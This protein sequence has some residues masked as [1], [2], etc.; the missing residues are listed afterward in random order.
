[1]ESSF[2]LNYIEKLLA[3]QHRRIEI[4]N[5]IQDEKADLME[6]FVSLVTSFA[7]RLGNDAATD[8]RKNGFQ[9]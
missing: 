3:L 7:A 9:H 2:G 8:K 5:P 1:L 4:L 6:D